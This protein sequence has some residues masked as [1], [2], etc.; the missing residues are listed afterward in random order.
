MS[1][2]TLAELA[3]IADRL[4]RLAGGR[5]PGRPSYGKLSAGALCVRYAIEDLRN[6]LASYLGEPPRPGAR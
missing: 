3:A 2:E 4:D 5:P 1:R 6:E